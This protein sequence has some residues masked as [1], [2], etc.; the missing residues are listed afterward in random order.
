MAY[1]MYI[2]GVLMPVTPSKV[3]LKIKNQNKTLNLI[4]GEEI[5]IL[6]SAGPD[7]NFF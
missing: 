5:N 4:N 1:K 2:A 6:K 3:Q 7:G